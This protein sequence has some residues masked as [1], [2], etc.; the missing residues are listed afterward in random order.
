[1]LIFF[2]LELG[3]YRFP[4]FDEIKLQVKGSDFTFDGVTFSLVEGNKQTN[5]TF[6]SILDKKF[7]YKQVTI[8]DVYLNLLK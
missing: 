5:Y 2:F 4:S 6:R 7:H 1:M 3:N 8:N